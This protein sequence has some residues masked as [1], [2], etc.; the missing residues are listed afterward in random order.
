MVKGS[1]KPAPRLD[2][3]SGC[4][5]SFAGVQVS[6]MAPVGLLSPER[7]HGHSQMH[8][9]KRNYSSPCN[10]GDPQTMLPSPGSPPFFPT[11]ISPSLPSTTLVMVWTAKLQTLS[12]AYKKNLQLKKKKTCSLTPLLLPG[13]GFGEEFFLY[14]PLHTDSLSLSV[15]LSP[16][17][18]SVIRAPSPWQHPQFFSPPNQPSAAPT[19]HDVA[20]FSTS[21]CGILL[22]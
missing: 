12:T 6:S 11:R 13:N 9:R 7:P 5:F 4:L 20:V 18:L 16:A 10:P 3:L 21:N 2:V 15:S 22:S 17:P 19:F 8:S 14:N 1:K